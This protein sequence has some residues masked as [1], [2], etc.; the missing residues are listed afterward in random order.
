[1]DIIAKPTLIA[2][3][4]E[5]PKRIEEYIGLVNSKTENISIARMVSPPGWEEP[6]QTPLFDEYTV[7]LQG[8]LTIE[9]EEGI[10]QAEA[11][12]AVIVPRNT[13]VRYSTPHPDGAEY[14]SVCLPAFSPATVRRD[15]TG[16]A[17]S[18][19]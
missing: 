9:T 7:V 4:G 15:E 16:R 14:I 11:G 6:G 18:R 2:A 17:S 12:A 10:Y 5:P 19:K 13:W 8:V 3:A 1:M